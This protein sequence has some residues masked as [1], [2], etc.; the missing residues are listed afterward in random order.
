M[1]V[2]E[3][4]EIFETISLATFDETAAGASSNGSFAPHAPENP[5]FIRFDNGLLSFDLRKIRSQ[6]EWS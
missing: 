5:D 6:S 1:R 2:S 4:W 3:V